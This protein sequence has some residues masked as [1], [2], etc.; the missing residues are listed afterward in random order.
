[1]HRTVSVQYSLLQVALQL[2]PCTRTHAHTYTNEVREGKQKEDKDKKA[3]TL[4]STL[5]LSN[6]LYSQNLTSRV[7]PCT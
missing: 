1:M 2:R 3:R 6:F 5:D 4:L 7:Q